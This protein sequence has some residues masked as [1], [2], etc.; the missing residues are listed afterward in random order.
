MADTILSRAAVL[1]GATTRQAAGVSVTYR[2]GAYT[3]A[4]TAVPG[5]T[6]FEV[7]GPDGVVLTV[8]TRDWKIKTSDIVLNSSTVIPAKGDEIDETVGDDT[9]T[10]RVLSPGG[11]TVYRYSDPSRKMLRVHT[12]LVETA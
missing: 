11:D 4:L 3:K 2:R 6:D 7:V 12:K 10:Y 5:S 1:L 8:Q 9:Q